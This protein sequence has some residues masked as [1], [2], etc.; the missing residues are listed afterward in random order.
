MIPKWKIEKKFM[1]RMA[2]RKGRLPDQEHLIAGDSDACLEYAKILQT[3]LP[4]HLENFL[5]DNLAQKDSREVLDWIIEYTK[6]SGGKTSPKLDNLFLERSIKNSK[7]P[8]D[9]GGRRIL[10]YCKAC[11]GDISP[12]LEELIWSSEHC[13]YQYAVNYN[14][15]IPK[16]YEKKV[17]E[18]VDD[19]DLLEYIK[20]FFKK[21]IHLCN[22]FK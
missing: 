16:E 4:E 13:A 1:L 15:K 9:F 21:V 5:V 6:I 10:N 12:K 7:S 19:D 11:N 17:L 18:G 3:R 22:S 2:K 14:K 20:K 8:Y